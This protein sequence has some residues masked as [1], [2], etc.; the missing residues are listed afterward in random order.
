MKKDGTKY[1]RPSSQNYYLIY[2][3]YFLLFY[4][5]SPIESGQKLQ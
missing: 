3:L 2:Q 5:H 1:G 4:L